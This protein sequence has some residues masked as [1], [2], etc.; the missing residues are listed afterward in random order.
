[1]YPLLV[2]DGDL[3]RK[4]LISKKIYVP[5]LWPNVLKET[6]NNM[7]EYYLANNIVPLPCDQRY[8]VDDM[9]YMIGVILDCLD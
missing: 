9:H 8:T 2:K 1:M 6:T 3:L 7:I 5:L 4:K